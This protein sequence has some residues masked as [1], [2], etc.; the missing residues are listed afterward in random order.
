MIPHVILIHTQ[1]IRDYPTDRPEFL[2]KKKLIRRKEKEIRNEYSARFMIQ[3]T[4]WR[5]LAGRD[6]LRSRRFRLDLYIF[7]TFALVFHIRRHARLH[8]SLSSRPRS[9]GI[10]WRRKS[11]TTIYCLSSLDSIRDS[12][13]TNNHPISSWDRCSWSVWDSLLIQVPARHIAS[14]L[15]SQHGFTYVRTCI[16][17]LQQRTCKSE[18]PPKYCRWICKRQFDLQRTRF[19]G[20]I[21]TRPANEQTTTKPIDDTQWI[22]VR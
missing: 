1:V 9:H 2:A 15:H 17:E 12:M 19:G 6:T 18:Q 14:T 5:W 16:R 3:Q 22:E 8:L 11:N 7:V 21:F 10:R 4:H 13:V 20:A